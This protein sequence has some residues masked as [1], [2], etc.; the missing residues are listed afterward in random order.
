MG[1]L[2][3]IPSPGHLGL[4][5]IWAETPHSHWGGIAAGGFVS[6]SL[7]ALQDLAPDTDP[8]EGGPAFRRP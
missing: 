8:T 7:P 4:Y 2:D 1:T 3:L 5:K 6:G